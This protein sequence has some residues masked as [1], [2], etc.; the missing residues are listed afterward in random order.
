MAFAREP[1]EIHDRAW[2]GMLIEIRA[3]FS[4]DRLSVIDVPLVPDHV[5]RRQPATLWR[6]PL[7]PQNPPPSG[8]NQ[9]RP[10][11]MILIQGRF[12]L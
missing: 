2:R 11:G 9:I 8:L 5:G 10:A 1:A 6:I 7:F 3:A 12:T 4:F